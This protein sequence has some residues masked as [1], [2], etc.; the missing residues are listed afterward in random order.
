MKYVTCCVAVFLALFAA[1]SSN[2]QTSQG[3]ILGN[4]H[5]CFGR[6][7]FQREGYG[8]QHGTGVSRALETNN[9]GEYDAP[10]LDPETTGDRGGR[11]F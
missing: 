5:R 1:V 4:G 2:A 7:R 11:W 9:V 3:R 6:S 8:R 10:S